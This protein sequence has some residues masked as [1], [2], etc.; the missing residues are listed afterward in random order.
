MWMG[1]YPTTPSLV[2]STS[3]D[4]Q[5]HLNANKEKLIGKNVLNTGFCPAASRDDISTFTLALT[6]KYSGGSEALLE[7]KLSSRGKE[8][9][10]REY[11]PDL[12]EFVM[13]VVEV[14]GKGE[15]EVMNVERNE[16]LL[17][18]SYMKRMKRPLHH[19]HYFESFLHL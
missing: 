14:V 5:K 15:K 19:L 11:R 16:L 12:S 4:L 2:L 13:A 9:R 17:V 6:F 7:A 3:E 1:T 18:Y 10:I 8:G